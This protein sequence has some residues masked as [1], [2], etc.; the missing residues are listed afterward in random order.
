M[1]DLQLYFGL[2]FKSLWESCGI[3]IL[4]HQQNIDLALYVQKNFRILYTETK[5]KLFY[6]FIYF[7]HN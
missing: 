5:K 6:L 2:K 3:E 1:L 4:S 7:L